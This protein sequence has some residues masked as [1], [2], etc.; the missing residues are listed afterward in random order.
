MVNLRALCLCAQAA[1]GGHDSGLEAEAL[2]SLPVAKGYSA[3]LFQEQHQLYPGRAGVTILVQQATWA[4]GLKAQTL[5]APPQFSRG[6]L[7]FLVPQLHTGAQAQ[8][9]PRARVRT[10]TDTRRQD[11]LQTRN[12]QKS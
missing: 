12:R 6:R 11:L 5:A 1:W 8:N 2:P 10:T 3:S 4:A 9:I 7:L